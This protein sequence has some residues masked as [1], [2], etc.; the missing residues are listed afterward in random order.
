MMAKRCEILQGREFNFIEKLKKKEKKKRKNANKAQGA[1]KE[2]PQ[3][4]TAILIWLNSLARKIRIFN[5]P[6]FFP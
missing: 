1:G 3:R 2:S 6:N 5:F 4:G